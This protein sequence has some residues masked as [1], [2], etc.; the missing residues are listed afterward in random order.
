MIVR[1][2][3]RGWRMPYMNY[4]QRGEHQNETQTAQPS[5]NAELWRHGA[6][7]THNIV[8]C[9]CSRVQFLFVSPHARGCSESFCAAPLLTS[10]DELLRSCKVWSCEATEDLLAASL[11]QCRWQANGNGKMAL[12]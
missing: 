12:F 10:S 5:A 8:E 1:A 3:L 9:I 2:H 11:Y 6:I 4:K 7:F